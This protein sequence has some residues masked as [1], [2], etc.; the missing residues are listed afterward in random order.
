MRYDFSPVRYSYN[1]VEGFHE[2]VSDLS[3]AHKVV[4][5]VAVV[6]NTIKDKVVEAVCVC[7]S[8]VRDRS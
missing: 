4:V 5:D 3:A 1:G 8:T 6:V 7:P 2:A